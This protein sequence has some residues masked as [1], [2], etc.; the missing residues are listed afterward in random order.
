MANIFA[1]TEPPAWLEAI[2]KPIDTKLTGQVFGAILGGLSNAH[3]EAKEKNQNLPPDKQT[4]FWEQLPD[5]FHNAAMRIRDPMYDIHMKQSQ[6]QLG[7]QSLNMQATQQKMNFAA[8]DMVMRAHDQQALADWLTKY[9]T[10]KSRQDAEAPI[11]ESDEGWQHYEAI[12]KGDSAQENQKENDRMGQR[13]NEMLRLA[14]DPT[15]AKINGMMAQSGGKITFEM[16]EELAKGEAAQIPKGEGPEGKWIHD[17]QT[18]SRIYGGRESQ[19]YKDFIAKSDKNLQGTI[20]TD[21]KTGER[22]F[23]Y[24]KTVRKLADYSAADQDRINVA[25]ANVKGALDPTTKAKAQEDFDNL[26]KS[27]D[28]GKAAPSGKPQ[29]KVIRIERAQPAAP[30]NAIPPITQQ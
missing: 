25:M 12:R 30:T 19:V 21:E 29:P 6:L 22:L 8:Q 28:S 11:L 4:S 17:E 27:L 10:L 3:Q 9:P 13:F 20:W 24:G 15:R 7:Q 18:I 23:L 14:D 26:M 2:A 1:G 5:S 16:Y